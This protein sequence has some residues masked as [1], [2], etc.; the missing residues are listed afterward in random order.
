MGAGGGP[1]I[2]VEPLTQRGPLVVG[3]D[4]E[5]QVDGF[6]AVEG[7]Q[8]ARDPVLDLVA[9]RAPGHGQGD[10]HA[11]PRL[12]DRDRA[13]HPEVDDAAME[14]GI[15]HGAQGVDDLGFG[16]WHGIGSWL[17]GQQG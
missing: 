12:G 15:L 7:G 13:H 16:D 5:V 8:G 4:R 17:E 1:G 2:A 10:L 6:D 11:D 3:H 14:L 9:Q